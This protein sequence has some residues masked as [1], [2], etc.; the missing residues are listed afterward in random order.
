MISD[1]TSAGNCC[2]GIKRARSLSPPGG[3]KTS[4]SGPAP[5]GWIG[6]WAPRTNKRYQRTKESRLYKCSAWVGRAHGVIPV[7][8][9]RV[10]SMLTAASSASV[11]LIFGVSRHGCGQGERAIVVLS[12]IFVLGKDVASRTRVGRAAGVDALTRRSPPGATFIARQRSWAG[13][14]RMA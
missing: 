3:G 6:Q 2:R 4:A 7:A 5:M 9:E 13:Q 12:R 14:S 8:V 11:T 1:L 10:R